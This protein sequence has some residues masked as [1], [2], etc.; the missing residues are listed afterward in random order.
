MIAMNEIMLP[1]AEEER[2]LHSQD[3]GGCGFR[4]YPLFLLV[5]DCTAIAQPIRVIVGVVFRSNTCCLHDSC[6]V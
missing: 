5:I 6:V 3:D 4:E 1:S 2:A